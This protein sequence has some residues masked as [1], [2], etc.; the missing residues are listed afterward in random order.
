MNSSGESQPS[1]LRRAIEEQSSDSDYEEDQRMLM[2]ARQAKRHHA[3][4]HARHH[5]HGYET[6]FRCIQLCL[7]V[8]ILGVYS[9]ICMDL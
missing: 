8:R 2:A 5:G 3:A 9:L 6:T 7:A 1:S 4:V